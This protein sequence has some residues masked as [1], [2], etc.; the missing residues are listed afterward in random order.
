MNEIHTIKI[1]SKISNWFF[2]YPHIQWI[3]TP[4]QWSEKHFVI[5]IKRERI[6]KNVNVWRWRG[7]SMWKDER[8]WINDADGLSIWEWIKWTNWLQTE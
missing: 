6:H 2:S 8:E 3:D 4:T 1:D 7:D 5:N